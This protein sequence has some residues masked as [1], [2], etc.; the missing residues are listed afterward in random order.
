MIMKDYPDKYGSPGSLAVHLGFTYPGTW[1]EP[2]GDGKSSL[3]AE[4][5]PNSDAAGS[6]GCLLAKLE[7]KSPPAAIVASK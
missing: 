7:K 3:L 1:C 2:L 4:K 6:G 5:Y